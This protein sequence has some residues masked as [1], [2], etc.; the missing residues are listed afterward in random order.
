MHQSVGMHV[1]GLVKLW[2]SLGLYG[3]TV[4]RL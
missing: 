3:R 2:T 4:K 1:T